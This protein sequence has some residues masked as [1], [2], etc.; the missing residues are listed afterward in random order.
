MMNTQFTQNQ[1]HL[2][3]MVDFMHFY[4]SKLKLQLKFVRFQ[5]FMIVFNQALQVTNQF[6]D[7]FV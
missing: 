7:P 1:T 4:N 3:A 5:P 6:E 2:N